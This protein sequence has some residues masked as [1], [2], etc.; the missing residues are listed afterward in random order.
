MQNKS[1]HLF[2]L[3]TDYSL[4]IF[5]Y[6]H[7]LAGYLIVDTD[8]SC[9]KPENSVG[10]YSKVVYSSVVIDICHVWYVPKE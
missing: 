8:R 5:I 7:F 4:G 2:F 6:F 3:A 1:L 9:K 10:C